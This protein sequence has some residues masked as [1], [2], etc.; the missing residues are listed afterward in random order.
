MASTFDEGDAGSIEI[1]VS[2][3]LLITGKDTSFAEQVDNAERILEEGD[4]ENL[5]QLINRQGVNGLAPDDPDN[6]APSGVFTISEESGTAGSIV[7]RDTPDN[8]H[9]ETASRVDQGAV[10]GR[11]DVVIRDDGTI[12]AQALEQGNAGSIVL[13]IS[14]E[15]EIANG[16]IRTDAAE[17]TGGDINIDAQT[18]QLTEGGSINARALGQGDAGN[19]IVDIANALEISDSDIRTDAAEAAGG[20]ITIEAGT[21][22]MTG[23]GDIRTN[24]A[25]GAGNGGNIFIVSDILIALDDSDILAFAQAGAGGNITLPTFFGQSFV[26]LPAVDNPNELDLNDRVDVNASGQLSSGVISFPDVSFIENSLNELPDTLINTESLVATSCIAQV[27][28]S[29]GSL[30]VTG[31]DGVPLNGGTFI[32]T[33]TVRSLETPAESE[34]WSVGDAISEPQAVYQLSDGRLVHSQ[35]CQ[36]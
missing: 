25:S 36:E 6:F 28:Q 8:T 21:I 10:D 14:G 26:L 13:D 29:S 3:Q 7:I 15:L 17:F 4:I 5:R 24:V 30:V 2:D 23:D 16:N 32:Q 31:A 33:G 1:F 35:D 19:I 27:A 20:S 12:S 18:L 11:L 34:S 22:L 9:S